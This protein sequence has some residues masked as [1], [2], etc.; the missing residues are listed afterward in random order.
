[1]NASV[2]KIRIKMFIVIKAKPADNAAESASLANFL[3]YTA[4]T[5]F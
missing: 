2:L 5:V 1:V 3:L 4:R